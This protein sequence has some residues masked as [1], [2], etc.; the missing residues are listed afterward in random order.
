M[1]QQDNFS[2][3]LSLT[4]NDVSIPTVDKCADG[5]SFRCLLKEKSPKLSFKSF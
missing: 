4:L 2:V 1:V 5:I 3:A